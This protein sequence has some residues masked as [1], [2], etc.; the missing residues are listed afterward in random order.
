MEAIFQ[1]V[2]D[3]ARSFAFTPASVAMLESVLWKMYAEIPPAAPAPM[4]MMPMNPLNGMATTN[5]GT[6]LNGAPQPNGHS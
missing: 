4:A 3:T 1:H 5:M 2:R 6:T